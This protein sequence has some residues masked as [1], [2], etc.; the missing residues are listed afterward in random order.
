M[1]SP[2][3]CAIK[4]NSF[5]RPLPYIDA[6]VNKYS[7]PNLYSVKI[8]C[9][10]HLVSTTY[11]MLVAL[12]ELGACPSNIAMIGKCYSSDPKAIQE[13][14]KL[15]ITVCQSSLMYDSHEEYD[16][17][18]RDNISS[19]LQSQLPSLHIHT[20]DNKAIILDDGGYLLSKIN[21]AKLNHDNIIGIEQ[22]SSGYNLLKEF[23]L[24]FPVLNVARSK[25][26]LINES[27]IIADQAVDALIKALKKCSLTPKKSLI[28]GNG[29]IGSSIKKRLQ[30]TYFVDT[31]DTNSELSSITKDEFPRC[32]KNYDLVIGCT[33]K[34]VLSHDEQKYLASN[35][36]LASVSSS[37]REF[38]AANF[39]K[40]TKK[41]TDPHL[42]VNISGIWLLNSGFPINFSNEFRL[43]DCDELQITRALLLKATLQGYNNSTSMIKSVENAVH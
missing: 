19:F 28:I 6:I 2:D 36:A 17:A 21:N 20:K 11:T 12:L 41:Q 24:K 5:Y 31:Y 8:L 10:Q 38:S 9:A 22:T 4:N 33:G 32:L 37:D 16:T 15:G 26:K 34:E 42:N 13:I 14:I 7:G 40:R 29:P 25:E 1:D 3:I 30:D 43:I 39:R 27:P 23:N 35:T 18:Y